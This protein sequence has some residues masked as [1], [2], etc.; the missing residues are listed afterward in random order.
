MDKNLIFSGCFIVSHLKN[1][2]LLV[3]E[4]QAA[5]TPDCFPGSAAGARRA[6]SWP[7]HCRRRSLRSVGERGCPCRRRPVGPRGAKISSVLQCI[8]W[9]P[10]SPFSELVAQDGST[11]ANIGLKMGQH[12]LKIGQHKDGPTLPSRYANI[13]PGW[14]NI[15][16]SC[17]R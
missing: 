7:W 4:T 15:A 14:A 12:V 16:P 11:W 1:H 17:L 8:L 5:A 2:L 9:L 13:A 10:F 6:R 3:S